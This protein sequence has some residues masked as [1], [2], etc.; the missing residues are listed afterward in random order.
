VLFRSYKVAHT[1]ELA[2][3]LESFLAPDRAAQMAQAAWR[4]STSGSDVMNQLIDALFGLEP[5]PSAYLE[6]EER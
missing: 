6:D 1:G 2:Y 4:V 3:A 5:Q